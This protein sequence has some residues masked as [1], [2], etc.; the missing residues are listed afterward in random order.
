MAGIVSYGAYVPFYRLERKEIGRAWGKRGGPGEKAVANFDEDSATMAVEAVIDCLGKMDRESI[1]GLYFASTTP[2]YKEKQSASMIAL[3]VDLRRQMVTGDF[4]NSLRSGTIALNAALN[5]VQGGAAK[6]VIVAAADTRLGVPQSEDEQ[7]FGDGAAALMIG[8]ENVAVE[9]EGTYSHADEILDT[10]RT[11]TDAFNRAWEDRFILTEGYVR[12]TKEA[13][14]NILKKCDLTPKDITKAVYYA[15]DARRHADMAKATGF[16]PKEQVQAPLFET[17]GNTGAALGLMMLV[18][19][20]EEAKPGDRLLFANYG[21]GCDAFILKVT[22]EIEKVR[23]RRGVKGHVSSK[24]A[25]PSYE[26]YLQ[27][28]KVL[29][30]EG[31]RRES[32]NAFP[33]VSWREREQLTSL[34]GSKCTSC[35][36]TFHPMQRVCIYCGAKDQFEGVRL[37]DRDGILFTFCKDMLALGGDPPTIVCKVHLA[38]SGGDIGVYCQ[39]TDRDPDSIVPDIPVEMTFRKMH[40]SGGMH[41]YYWKCR[42]LREPVAES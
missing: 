8:D 38:D 15:P 33:P 3:A 22:E 35:G 41:T 9:I 27:L 39:M 29:N 6:K 30:I 17:V 19:A 10:W 2:P 24:R 18:A 23:D 40:D 11:E 36:R 34:H 28:R 32:A 14:A 13:I 12:N 31:Q 1:D 4:S 5:A 42:P 7:N 16:D 20:L 26:K 21:D 25:L 37:S